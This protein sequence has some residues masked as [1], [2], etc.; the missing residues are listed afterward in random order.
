MTLAALPTSPR[1]DPSVRPALRT[2]VRRE[3]P[4]TVIILRG[5]VD[6]STRPVLAKALLRVIDLPAGDVVIDLAE[7]EFVDRAAVRVM[8]V[9]QQL[10]V[11]RG[12]KLTFRSPSRLSE[13]ALD[14]FGLTGLIEPR[15]ETQP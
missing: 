2:V 9:G 1:T 15:E 10:L 6:F 3:G 12:R 13:R 5:K 11:R 14:P 8:S 4:R 7:A